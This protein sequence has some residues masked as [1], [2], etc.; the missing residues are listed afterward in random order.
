M[1]RIAMVMENRQLRDCWRRMEID[2][3]GEVGGSDD[4]R[5]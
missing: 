2:D 1:E 5:G 3:E 4:A